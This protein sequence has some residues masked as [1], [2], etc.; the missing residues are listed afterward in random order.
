MPLVR[1]AAAH[2]VLQ[3]GEVGP[4]AA[5]GTGGAGEGVDRA[6][7]V[8]R[9]PDGGQPAVDEQEHRAADLP[10]EGLVGAQAAAGLPA[11]R[12]GPAVV[13]A[14]AEPALGHG[15]VP[16]ADVELTAELPRGVDTV[17]GELRVLRRRDACQILRA[18]H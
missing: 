2:G 4:E 8:V 3:A 12:A 10:T 9:L 13:R 5:R 14:A 6:G 7:A 16:G 1:G 17:D 15:H 11:T 18:G